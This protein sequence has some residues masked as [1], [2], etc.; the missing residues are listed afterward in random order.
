MDRDDDGWDNWSEARYTSKSGL[1]TRPDQAH[2]ATSVPMPEVAFTFHYPGLFKNGSL[3]VLA[4]SRRAMDGEPDAIFEMDAPEYFPVTLS[5]NGVP[6]VG[7]LRQGSNWFFAFIDL[8][9]NR[10]WDPGEPAG[11]AERFPYDVGWDKNAISFTLSDAP[12]NG[13]VRMKMPA[14]TGTGT[15]G[16][17]IG[18]IT[19]GGVGGTNAIFTRVFFKYIKGPRNWIHEGDILDPNAAVGGGKPGLDWDGRISGIPVIPIGTTSTYEL[20]V[21]NISTT[22]YFAINYLG[23]TLPTPVAEYPRGAVVTSPRPEFRW[24]MTTV[25]SAFELQILTTNASPVVVYSSGTNTAPPPR[26]A[27]GLRVWS[28]PIHW[29][30]IVPALNGGNGVLT[31]AAFQW[32]VRA[33][34]PRLVTGFTDGT[35]YSSSISAYSS[36]ETVRVNLSDTVTGL[37]SIRVEIAAPYLPPNARIRVQAFTTASFN[38]LPVVQRTLIGVTSLTQ[39]VTLNG[40]QNQKPYFVAAYIDQNADNA[41]A[42]WESWGYYRL[43]DVNPEFWFQPVMIQAGKLTQ[44]PLVPLTIM[45]TDTDQDRIADAYEYAVSGGLSGIPT[46]GPV[47]PLALGETSDEKVSPDWLGVL[48]LV[49]GSSVYG[50]Y[51]GDG[52]NDKREFDLGLSATATDE[53]HITGLDADNQL[54][55]TL[56]SAPDAVGML[57][58]TTLAQP[59]TYVLERTDSLATPSWIPVTKFG[60]K[61]KAGAFDLGADRHNRPA[62]FYRVRVITP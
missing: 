56:T 27:D 16:V 55:W 7:R 18:R 9:G 4:Y 17:D 37:G 14:V 3:V 15:H 43:I 23:T 12:I 5:T 30:D 44:A 34:Q 53:L 24:T 39:I 38:D 33:F 47:T 22:N 36:S 31:N 13:F 59:V 57:S 60:S 61:E 26:N 29:G 41:R 10:E 40:L 1:T 2:E 51:D 42:I 62:G 8:S 11:L 19:W 46:G 32:R 25:A 50:D 6:A 20:R 52:L 45:Y 54:N 28:P 21:N 49:T 58:T 35:T 48:G